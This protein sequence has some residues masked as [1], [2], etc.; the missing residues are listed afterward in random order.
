[1][2]RA[3]LFLAACLCAALPSA[4]QPPA[5][6]GTDTAPCASPSARAFDFWLG[7][8]DVTRPDGAPAG[9]SHVEAILDGCVVFEHWTSATPPYAGKSLNVFNRATGRWEQFWVDN[10]GARL[11]LAG[12]FADGRMV[13]AGEPDRPDPKTGVVPRERI[14]WTPNADGS[15]RQL[16]ESSSDGG[17]S[18]TVAFDG[19]YLR[20]RPR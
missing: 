10:A 9:R 19:L 11:H 7:D 14:T 12:G 3:P 13:L 2:Q 18:W 6:G 16:W 15:V 20:A 8:W 1:M 4:A 17:R 5:P